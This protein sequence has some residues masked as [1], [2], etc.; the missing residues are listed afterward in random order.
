MTIRPHR[1]GDADRSLGEVFARTRDLERTSSGIF[2]YVGSGLPLPDGPDLSGNVNAPPFQNG[3]ANQGGGKQALRF[4]WVVGGGIDLQ[5]ACS[6][7]AL[8]TVVFTLP[9]HPLYLPDDGEIPVIVSDNFGNP[10]VLRI[11]PSGD[12]IAGL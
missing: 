11:Q 4:R 6:G 2:I 10:L 7:G 1:P 12:V 8:T 3:W 9:N 5:G